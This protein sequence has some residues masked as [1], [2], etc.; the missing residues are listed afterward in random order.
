[1]KGTYLSDEKFLPIFDVASKKKCLLFLHPTAPLGADKLDEHGLIRS[2]G[3]TFETTVCLVKMA[4]SGLFDKFP[5]LKL[6]SAHLAGAIP[7]L[8]GR[9]DTAWKNFKDSKGKLNEPP[10]MKIRRVLFADTISYS[11]TA[12]NLA[13][14]FMGIDRLFFGTDYPFDWGIKDAR[15]SIESTFDGRGEEMQKVYGE[16]FE[17]VM[18]DVRR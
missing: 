17:S 2:V 16:N 10:T 3:Y 13:I 8:Q 12:L 15:D 11:T 14:A 18:Q 9:I 4:Y 5:N 1:V 7:Y 6:L